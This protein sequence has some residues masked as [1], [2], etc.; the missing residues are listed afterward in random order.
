MD[1]DSYRAEVN[2]LTKN[3]K[4]LLYLIIF[5]LSKTIITISFLSVQSQFTVVESTRVEPTRRLPQIQWDDANIKLNFDDSHHSQGL[6]PGNN[7]TFKTCRN[8]VQGRSYITDD[9]GK[10]MFLGKYLEL[11]WMPLN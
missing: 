2:N 3:V 7:K 10:K 6:D 11:E 5:C 8:S 1:D 9:K 4:W